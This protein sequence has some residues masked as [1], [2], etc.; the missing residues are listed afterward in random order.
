VR[1]IRSVRRVSSAWFVEEDENTTF[2][3]WIYV[4]TSSKPF[5]SKQVFRPAM[6]TAFLPPTLIPRSRATYRAI[7]D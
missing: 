2:P 5:S 4:R 7:L 1:S 3:L 6:G